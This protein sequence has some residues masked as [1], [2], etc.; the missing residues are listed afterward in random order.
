[1]SPDNMKI[2]P[3]RDEPAPIRSGSSGVFAG[4]SLIW[5]AVAGLI[6]GIAAVY[7]QNTQLA[8]KVELQQASLS[9]SAQ[10]IQ[11][12]E[13][14]L[15]ATGRD[16]SK[17]G[18]TLEKRLE[19]SEHEIRKLWDLS[20]KRNKVDIAKNEATLKQL[21]KEI[22]A[23]G[24]SQKEQQLTMTDERA[25]RENIDKALAA[26]QQAF[27]QRLTAAAS[28]VSSMGID[29]KVLSE[30]QAQLSADLAEA[31]KDLAKI[32]S[33][34]IQ[35]IENTVSVYD[36]RLDAI[37]ASRRQLTSNVT[38][39]NTDVNRLQ[40]EVNALIKSDQSQP[41]AVVAPAQ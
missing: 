24:A 23:L 16:L 25:T 17:S 32:D 31:K 18:N 5:F 22:K 41:S 13:D 21:T 36:E 27:H 29:L 39:L 4:N 12:L 15:V 28:D 37:D 9:Q 26:E 35:N 20:N 14:E 6:A 8:A 38:R 3:E 10:R 34:A 1:M 30:T 11:L 19:V 33:T 2:I 7:F 40:L